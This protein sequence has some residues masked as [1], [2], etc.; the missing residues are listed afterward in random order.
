MARKCHRAKAISKSGQEQMSAGAGQSVC[1]SRLGSGCACRK[2]TT[3]LLVWLESLCNTFRL[4]PWS[5]TLATG[6]HWELHASSRVLIQFIGHDIT[7]CHLAECKGRNR[8]TG[9][10]LLS[11]MLHLQLTSQGITS[12]SVAD[13]QRFS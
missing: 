6:L 8:I 10:H 7:S 5:R 12:V 4:T 1:P 3:P 11:D 2:G 13:T 9:P